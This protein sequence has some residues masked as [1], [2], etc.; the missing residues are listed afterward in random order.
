MELA[1]ITDISKL[2]MKTEEVLDIGKIE[3]MNLF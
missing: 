1:I 2:A 3:N